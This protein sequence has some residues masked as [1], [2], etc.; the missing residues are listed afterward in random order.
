MIQKIKRPHK[1]DPEIHKE[2]IERF[3]N[4][5]N[6][7]QLL[8]NTKKYNENET[9]FSEQQAKADFMTS[10][11]FNTDGYDIAKALDGCWIYNINSDVVE[12]IENEYFAILEDLQQEK[13]LEWAKQNPIIPLP[14]GTINSFNPERQVYFISIPYVR[15][16]RVVNAED[17][18]VDVI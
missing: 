7:F 8:C 15:G 14:K 1:R 16:W 18:T 10:S 17:V 4:E 12:M 5:T 3:F 2:A 13:E 9:K 6:I 11:V